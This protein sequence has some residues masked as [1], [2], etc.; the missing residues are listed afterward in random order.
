MKFEISPSTQTETKRDSSAILIEFVSWET[1][2]GFRSVSSK[3]ALKRGWFITLRSLRTFA[4]AALLLLARTLNAEGAEIRRDPR[5]P[6]G[7]FKPTTGLNR[8][9]APSRLVRTRTRGELE[10]EFDA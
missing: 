10:T 4:I 8:T 9:E 1:V 6:Q 3:S 5:E 7:V 2:N